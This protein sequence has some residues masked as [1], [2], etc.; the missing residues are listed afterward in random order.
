MKQTNK[1]L[2]SLLFFSSMLTLQALSQGV[3]SPKRQPTSTS[4]KPVTHTGIYAPDFSLP[5]QNSKQF[6]L[7][8]FRGRKVLMMFY[9]GYWC[10]YC[11]GQLSDFAK[12]KGDFEKLNITLVAISVDDQEHA[13]QVWKS[14]VKRQFDVLR[15]TDAQVIKKYGILIDLGEDG[16]V[17]QRTIYLVDE[18]GYQSWR[19]VSKSLEDISSAEEILKKI[20]MSL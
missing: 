17:A 8:S 2:S 7:E 3:P 9:R 4:G 16:Q 10:S 1:A 6:H 11:M 14:V 19:K 20:R 5:D 13:R 12:H 15:D 18:N